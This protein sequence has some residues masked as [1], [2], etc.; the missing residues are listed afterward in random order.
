[1]RTPKAKTRLHGRHALS[2]PPLPSRCLY[3]SPTHTHQPDAVRS[4]L[5]GPSLRID[6]VA[7]QFF[8]GF[9]RNDAVVVGSALQRTYSTYVGAHAACAWPFPFP[10]PSSR[11]ALPMLCLEGVEYCTCSYGPS[12]LPSLRGLRE[13]VCVELRMFAPGGGKHHTPPPLLCWL[14]FPKR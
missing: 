1:M 8:E 7:V 10:P 13:C 11:C 2:L 3:S 9:A 6:G 5:I 14:G 4:L 12:L